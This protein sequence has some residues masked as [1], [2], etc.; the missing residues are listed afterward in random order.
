MHTYL[1]RL[2]LAPFPWILGLLLTTVLACREEED[3]PKPD[4]LTVRITQPAAAVRTREASLF[5]QVAVE[6]GTADRVELLRDGEPLAELGAS[7]SYTWEL[8]S[9][10]EGTYP[11]TARAWKGQ[12]SYTSEPLSVSVDRT[13]PWVVS[14][15]PNDGAVDVQALAPVILEFSEPMDPASLQPDSIEL[16]SGGRPVPVSAELTAG[17]HTLT[18]TPRVRTWHGRYSHVVLRGARDVA[19][20]PMQGLGEPIIDWTRAEWQHLPNVAGMEP[21]TAFAVHAD[22]EGVPLVA[23]AQLVGGQYSILVKRWSGTA[24]D[25]VGTPIRVFSNHPPVQ[26]SLATSPE[27][28]P[29]VAWASNTSQGDTE[30]H[31][32]AWTGSAW[33]SLGATPEQP[34]FPVSHPAPVSL[35]VSSQGT[36][37]LAF[38]SSTTAPIKRWSG[39]AWEDL[40]S[41]AVTTLTNIDLELGAEGPVVAVA[42]R[43]ADPTDTRISVWRWVDGGW[44]ALGPP[45]NSGSAATGP[46]VLMLELNAAGSPVVGY[47][48]QHP[49]GATMYLWV[50][51]WDGAGWPLLGRPPELGS[52][53][54]GTSPKWPSLA[55]D[56]TGAPWAA[57]AYLSGR[58]PNLSTTTDVYRWTGTDWVYTP[59]VYLEDAVIPAQLT[60]AGDTAMFAAGRSQRWSFRASVRLET[61]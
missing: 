10:A 59:S 16:V 55:L 11:L 8:S 47:V 20:N 22:A 18:M 23:H 31:A 58:W 25:A 32:Q 28:Q 19:G 45:F 9:V 33:Q 35:R 60:R 34:G 38:K 39:S 61:Y 42:G 46:D 2:R 52:F 12:D 53:F 6:D 15:L 29:W 40:P 37:Y 54:G 5:V 30:V 50:H 41:P 7:L 49:N 1:S 44:R 56:D 3:P 51:A 4:P 36:A 27:G 24:W 14:S 13:G 43:H 57:Y 26:L 48:N 21:D 17:G